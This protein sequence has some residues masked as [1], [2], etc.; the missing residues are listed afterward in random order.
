MASDGCYHQLSAIPH[1]RCWMFVSRTLPFSDV[2]YEIGE[3]AFPE[4]SRPI[5]FA[6]GERG[7]WSIWAQMM[8]KTNVKQSTGTRLTRRLCSY[9]VFLLVVVFAFSTSAVS[10]GEVQ[11]LKP[12]ANGSTYY[13]YLPLA[14]GAHPSDLEVNQ[15]VQQ[16]GNPV[17]LISNRTTYVRFTLT[18][19]TAYTG[20]NAY[21]HGTQSGS[22]LPG[23]RLSALNNP[24]T[25]EASANRADLNDTFNFLLPVSWTSGTVE[26]WGSAANAVDADEHIDIV[27]GP[28]SFT[29]N[30]NDPLGVTVVPIA[31]TCSSGGSG[32]TTPVGPFNYLVDLTSR[33]YPAPSINLSPHGS[34]AY[35]GACS[36]GVPDPTYAPGPPY[37]D[38]DWENMLNLVTLVWEGEG[39]PNNYYYGLVDIDCSGGCI[40]G[41][42]WLNKK[43]AVGFNGVGGGHSGASV[44]H[45]HEVGHNHGR[46]HAPGC[47]V[48]GPDPSYP[49]L[50]GSGRGVI[51][52]VDNPNY[53]FDIST[54]GIYVY[55]S[56][57][58][59]MGYCGPSW[60]S[61]Y[62]YEAFYNFEVAQ[63][64]MAPQFMD[65]GEDALLVSGWLNEDGSIHLQPA[66]QLNVPA[67]HSPP[68][69]F[70]LELLDRDGTQLAIYPFGM[71][72]AIV[73]SFAGT[74]AGEIRAFY[75]TIPYITG[76]EQ[77]KVRKGGE[78]LG[79][80]Q[81]T[82]ALPYEIPALAVLSA[83]P[84]G[85][86]LSAAWSGS[87]GVSYLVR[88]SLDHGLTWQIVA[89][90][91]REPS[92]DL[93][94]G[95]VDSNAIRLEIL[96]SDGIHTEGIEIGVADLPR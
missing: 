34:V 46:Y 69:E 24:R 35:S 1:A 83:H 92:V 28:I 5:P 65:P 50:N 31:Y 95:E 52:D 39:S 67:V 27:H 29:F 55:S 58:D 82:S 43:A 79:E 42:G 71:S 7:N 75:L 64:A 86:V 8:E 56:Y 60:I 10:G 77:I 11:Q 89:V 80:L 26:L 23:S 21:L 78:V 32:T 61:D 17:T 14:V 87:T 47:G 53:G 41:L 94:L 59:I 16:P 33:I 37:D 40:S 44:T 84:Q 36:S 49:Y 45:A 6:H 70:A 12:Q 13:V 88:L 15:A 38:S 68:G 3:I 62:T 96:A 73:D 19:S 90:N 51:G 18:S 20:V 74:T 2:Y 48:S 72:T 85:G 93:L 57:Y 30:D 81:A 54:M 9:L 76:I 66:F 91:Q 4:D 63:P 25:L 22:P